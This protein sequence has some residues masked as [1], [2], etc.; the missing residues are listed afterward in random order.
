[1]TEHRRPQDGEPAICLDEALAGELWQLAREDCPDDLRARLENHVR[2]CAACRLQLAVER[3]IAAGLAAGDLRI[4][5]APRRSLPLW[6]TGA[7]SLA[8]AAGL[9]LVL[10]LPPVAPHFADVVRG[11]GEPLIERPVPDEVVLG[12]RPTLRW[13]PV[14]GATSYEVR[15]TEVA[16]GS[17]WS[18]RTAA[19]EVRIPVGFELDGDARYRLRVDPT[20]AHLAPPGGMTTS[21]RTADAGRWAGYRLTHAPAGVRW[22]GGLGLAAALAGVATLLAGRFRT[23]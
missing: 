15:V 16:G 1:M 14:F 17:S 21:F 23:P 4:A 9:A 13:A 18:T 19:T 5:R 12:N 22:L 3:S 2:Y 6:L 10:L 8:L 20:P 7:G 11:A